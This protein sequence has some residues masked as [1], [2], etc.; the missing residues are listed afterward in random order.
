MKQRKLILLFLVNLLNGCGWF[1]T[2]TPYEI[3]YEQ[4]TLSNWDEAIQQCDA[5][6]QANPD[7]PTVLMLRGRSLAAKG[8][9]DRAIQIFSRLIELQ[10]EDAEAYYHRGMVYRQQG[11]T[12]LAD[13]DK[14][15]GRE[16]DTL[17]EA[18]YPFGQSNFVAKSRLLPS[19]D[20][21]ETESG[22]VAEQEDL[23]TN[24]V[25]SIMDE[26][27]DLIVSDE[28]AESS[29]TRSTRSNN[30]DWSTQKRQASDTPGN[31]PLLMPLTAN[32][33]K[34][35]DPQLP[36]I[37]MATATPTNPPEVNPDEEKTSLGKKV[38][39]QN[40]KFAE[41][42][43]EQ[44]GL[45]LPITLQPD[46]SLQQPLNDLSNLKLSTSLQV[47]PTDTLALPHFSSLPKTGVSLDRLRGISDSTPGA[48]PR[49][50]RGNPIYNSPEKSRLSTA[51]PRQGPTA[52]DA[53]ASPTR[54][55]RSGIGPSP[56]VGI[57]MDKLRTPAG[58]LRKSNLPG[59]NGLGR[60]GPNLPSANLSTGSYQP[61]P[62]L[63]TTGIQSRQR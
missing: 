32:L 30:N 48:M 58:L 21:I 26:E 31:S 53:V 63:P 34:A 61:S 8:E 20:K 2:P 49:Q 13:A 1:N 55:L 29:H 37:E 25:Q 18:A 41:D 47:N 44:K 62:P 43:K 28:D 39:P 10:P 7:N 40:T 54:N 27:D 50:F 24:D 33:P 19:D 11:K 17:L 22:N 16:F 38:Q 51:I 35:Q 4:F 9:L 56:V 59:T 3:A 6:L 46:D 52:M 57:G 12:E 42:V 23:E 14:A 5:M 36:Q 15:R 60:L 45:S